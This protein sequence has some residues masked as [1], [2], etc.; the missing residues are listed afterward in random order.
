LQG[1]LTPKGTLV[2]NGGGSPGHVFGPIGALLK[3]VVVNPF[4]SQRLRPLPSKT[5]RQELLDVTGLIQDGKLTA[6]VD[7]TYPLAET[8][9]GLRHVELGHTRGKAIV[10]V[11]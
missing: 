7:R 4:V 11:A 10:T 8:A 6:I 5:D 3:A 1:V 9:E 2:L